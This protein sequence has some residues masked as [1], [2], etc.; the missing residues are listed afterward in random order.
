MTFNLVYKINRFSLSARIILLMLLATIF[1][2]FISWL[3]NQFPFNQPLAPDESIIKL[4]EDVGPII[5][6]FLA[7]VLVPF[8]ETVLFQALI[9]KV[10]LKRSR[11]NS[12]IYP[13][14]ISAIAFSL[15]H[16]YS[17]IYVVTTFFIGLCLA[18]LYIIVKKRKQ[19]PILVVSTVHA[20]HN[21]IVFTLEQI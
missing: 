19:S 15:M 1:N 7:V 13:I 18:T 2:V 9:I 17:M 16:I 4:A 20:I 11:G 21:L 5:F 10:N 12:N 3:I 6:F 8:I 14:I